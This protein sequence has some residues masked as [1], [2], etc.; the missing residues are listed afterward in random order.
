MA[1][2]SEFNSSEKQVG[3]LTETFSQLDLEKEES[4]FVWKTGSQI[5][6]AKPT[7]FQDSDELIRE[8]IEEIIPREK[9]TS[10]VTEYTFAV[11]AVKWILP[12]EKHEI[13][14]NNHECCETCKLCKI[15]SKAWNAILVKYN[16]MKNELL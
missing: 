6:I 14:Y 2:S 13:I 9:H 7:N 1:E 16:G 4:L 15:F 5:T 3:D 10:I 12:E 8:Y 11:K